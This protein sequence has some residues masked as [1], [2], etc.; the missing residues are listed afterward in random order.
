MTPRPP[1]HPIPTLAIQLTNLTRFLSPAPSPQT[2]KT[3]A[4]AGPVLPLPLLTIRPA[5]CCCPGP[6]SNRNRPLP[7]LAEYSWPADTQLH[8][9]QSPLPLAPGWRCRL[10]LPPA[11]AEARCTLT[12]HTPCHATAGPLFPPQ[13]R[14]CTSCWSFATAASCTRCSTRAAPSACPSAR[15]GSTSPRYCWHCSTCTCRA[16]CTG[17]C[18]LV[19]LFCWSC[20]LCAREKP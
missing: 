11:P 17:G 18:S 3:C 13:T 2:Y 4:G 6:P 1:P 14:T 19:L 16:S 10:S 8:F 5:R 7:G 15:R 20:A 9:L 12:P